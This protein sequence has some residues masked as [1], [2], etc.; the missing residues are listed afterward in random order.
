M[1]S[2]Q[3]RVLSGACK[4]DP[5]HYF[6]SSIILYLWDL[7]I[8]LALSSAHLLWINIAETCCALKFSD[9]IFLFL[10][11]EKSFL[12]TLLAPCLDHQVL[13]QMISD[14]FFLPDNV[15][16]SVLAGCIFNIF[17]QSKYQMFS[18]ELANHNSSYWKEQWTYPLG[19][20]WV[21][22]FISASQT[23]RNQSQ[24]CQCLTTDR[25]EIHLL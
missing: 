16:R 17:C 12:V 23:I 1:E 11:L 4:R 25:G 15:N 8:N 24:W 21:T 2:K 3:E 22:D 13:L 19:S 7:K 6:F 18:D 5:W 14:F 20:C 10:F 9:P